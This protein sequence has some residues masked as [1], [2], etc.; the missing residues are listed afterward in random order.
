MNHSIKR[1]M[2]WFIECFIFFFAK[3]LRAL[4]WLE[5]CFIL[6]L[7]K[8]SKN[9][10]HKQN[11]LSFIPSGN[12]IAR[13]YSTWTGRWPNPA[14]YPTTLRPRLN[15]GQLVMIG[16]ILKS[17]SAKICKFMMILHKSYHLRKFGK[18]PCRKSN[19]PAVVA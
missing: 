6:I 14:F 15:A 16:L 18:R 7:T 9:L 17:S 2:E 4:K 11:V 12:F 1:I 3:R 5:K 10:C 19:P 13:T 8:L